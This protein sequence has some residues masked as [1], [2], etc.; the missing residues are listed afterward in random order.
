MSI[1]ARQKLALYE[2][3]FEEIPDVIVLKDAKGDF[4]LCN[5]TMADLYHTTPDAM[6]GKHDSDFGV[7]ADLAASFRHN[8]LGIMARGE[9]EVVFEDSRDALTG[10]IRHFKSTKRPFKDAHGNNQ[11]LVIAHDIT[12]V[13]RAQQQVAQ[14]EQRLRDVMTATREGIWDWHLPTGRLVHNQQWFSILGFSE[15]DVDSHID[16]FAG[17]LHPDDKPKV[18]G[19]LQRLLDGRDEFY[20]S[21]HRMICKDGGS[22]WVLDRGRVAERDAQ[23][24]PVR[25]VGAY[26]DIS[27]RKQHEVELERLLELARAGTRAKS[28][29]LTTMSHELRTPLNG[30]L[31][32]AQLLLLPQLSPQELQDYA[33]TILTSGQS[34]LGLLDNILDLSKV[35]AGKLELAPTAFNPAHLLMQTVAVFEPLAQSKHL[36][37]RVDTGTLEKSYCCGDATRLRQMLT[38]YLGNAIKFTSQGEVLVQVAQI[39]DDS[40]QRWLEFSVQ[41]SGIGIAADKQAL[42]FKPFS[43]ADSSTTREFGGTGLGLSIVAKLAEFMGGSTGLQSQLGKGSRFWFRVPMRPAPA[44][45]HPEQVT[46]PIGRSEPA[47]VLSGRVLVAEDN[48]INRMVIKALLTKL[49]LQVEFADNGHVAFE[50]VRQATPFDV[51]LMDVQMPIMDGQ[52]ATRSIRQWEHDSGAKRTPIIALTASAFDDDRLRCAEAGMD[53]FLTKPIT[54][55]RLSSA[56]S[57]WLK[58]GR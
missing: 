26:A 33:R 3:V 10:E 25:M 50:R 39:N 15:G 43:Q 2:A 20:S 24:K 29:F 49:A 14:S 11:I 36:T 58:G 8:V 27:E 19:Q 42:L 51:I 30:I 12:D 5:R 21:E 38:N 31:G 44:P 34:L 6:V 32:M 4:L 53:D 35:E 37:L 28:D 41:D 52:Q 1:T 47:D 9:V 56:L 7:P 16:A 18:W 17:F 54:L 22:I 45:P 57:R 23:G 55:A 13:V 40:G 48:P 46:P